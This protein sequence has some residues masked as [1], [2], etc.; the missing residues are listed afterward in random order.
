MAA[1]RLAL[2]CAC[3][4]RQPSPFERGTAK[5]GGMSIEGY[6][7]VFCIRVLFLFIGGFL[8]GS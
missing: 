3:V 5:P 1:C 8:S 2:V 4:V 7:V 6:G